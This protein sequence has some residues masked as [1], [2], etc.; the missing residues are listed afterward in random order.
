MVEV[1]GFDSY[2][3]KAKKQDDIFYRSD[4]FRATEKIIEDKVVED[5]LGPDFPL[6]AIISKSYKLTFFDMQ[7]VIVQENLF[8]AE[9]CK[10]L[11]SIPPC[12][13]NSELYQTI[14]QARM[15]FH[16]NLRRSLGTQ[17]TSKVNERTLLS[18]Q[19]K[20]LISSTE[21]TGENRGVFKKLFGLR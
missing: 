20:H 4:L 10:L 21:Q 6:W 18:S 2:L 8:E 16:A 17:G 5:R 3:P 12:M 1:Q 11:R 15:I 13:H 7:D 19:I 9:V 14:G